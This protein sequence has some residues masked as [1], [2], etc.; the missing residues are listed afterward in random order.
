MSAA[1]FELR[2][3]RILR[4]REEGYEEL[5]DHL[6]RFASLGP[7]V[8]LGLLRRREENGELQ[9][10]NGYVPT[11]RGLE[12]MVYI[13][14]KELVLVRPGMAVK[15]QA[16]LRKDPDKEAVF[17]ETYAEP[18]AAQFSAVDEQ[19]ERAGR[20]VWRIQRADQLKQLLQQGYM[21]ITA[22]TKRTGVGEGALLRLGLCAPVEDRPHDRA[23][24]LSITKE[25]SRYLHIAD[26]WALLLV[27]P[28][29]ELPL[30]E[31]CE[32]AKAQYWCALP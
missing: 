5:T 31:R 29:M 7:L 27:K 16:E 4:S 20:D 24:S 18:T 3:N 12:Y 15:L 23:L 28:G 32:P 10:Y 8:R 2:W 30:F 6:G 13:A 9:R 21:D 19:R 26:P 11:E 14:E 25:G 17:K 1:A 22:F